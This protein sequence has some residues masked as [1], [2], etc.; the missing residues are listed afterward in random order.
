MASEA[1]H[2]IR[3]LPMAPP[4]AAAADATPAMETEKIVFHIVVPVDD[5][6][7]HLVYAPSEHVALVPYMFS[8]VR[9]ALFWVLVLG[10]GGL[11]G[12][13]SVWFPQLFTRVA[14]ARL[15]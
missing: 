8:Y 2:F 13:V 14:R 12:I 4:A 6:A 9:L 10:T 5:H 7:T 3:E 15:P 11:F 1:T